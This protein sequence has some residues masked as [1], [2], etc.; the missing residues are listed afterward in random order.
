MAITSNSAVALTFQSTTFEIVDRDGQ[1]WLRCPQIGDA[2]GYAKRGGIAIDALY[3]RNAAEFTPSMTALVKVPTAGG[4]QETRIFSLRGA[5]LLGMF[6]RTTRAAEFRHWVLNV[7]EGTAE[8]APAALATPFNPGARWLA[9]VDGAGQVVFAP[10]PFG[11]VTGT[12]ADLAAAIRNNGW[13][14]EDTLAMFNACAENL[15]ARA[16]RAGRSVSVPRERSK[17]VRGVAGGDAA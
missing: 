16:Q 12:P 15:Q 3:K 1:P 11:A 10:V 8:P 17:A 2:L 5:H 6:A 9:T 7:L 13:R 4:E 14:F